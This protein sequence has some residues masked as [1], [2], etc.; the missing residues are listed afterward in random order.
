MSVIDEFEEARDDIE[1]L[2]LEVLGSLLG[3][4]EVAP[5]AGDPIGPGPVLESRLVIHDRA[6]DSYTVVEVETALRVGRVI[7]AR[8][9]RVADPSPEDLLDV[10]AELGNIIAGNVK[11]LIRHSCRLSLPSADVVESPSDAGEHGVRVS[12]SVLGQV[13]QLTVRPALP[14]EPVGDVRWPGSYDDVLETQS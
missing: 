1:A 13:I 10:V 14:R 11:S 9:M 12:A 7:A 3:A 8:M 6:D 4:D 2:L 5:S